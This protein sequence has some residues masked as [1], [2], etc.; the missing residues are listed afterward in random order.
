MRILIRTSKWAIWSRRFGSFAVPITV[1]PILLHRERLLESPS[2]VTIEYIALAVAGLAVFL[3]IGAYAR[4]WVTGDQGW[5][6]ATWGLFFGLLCLA[7]FGYL[8]VE[9]Y[10]Y[11][12]I[13]EID[14]DPA[15]PPVLREARPEP[16]TPAQLAAI[17]SKFPNA[18]SRSYPIEATQMFALVREMIEQ[19]GWEERTRRSPQTALDEGQINAIA[20]SLLGWRDE[21]AVRVTGDAQG[22]DVAMRSAPLHQWHDFGENGRRVEEFLLALDQR[23]TL[24]L[25]DAANVPAAE[26]E[27]EAGAP[28]AGN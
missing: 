5:A 4:L 28:A 2:F 19:R 17:A 14:T 7:P 12:R 9:V 25:R 13:S 3:A 6:K 26:S 21:V 18:Q 20:M 27:A 8:G 24:L 15:R 10:R 22:S 11:P 16:N 23:V 1:L